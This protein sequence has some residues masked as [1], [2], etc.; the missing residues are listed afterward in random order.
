MLCSNQ[1]RK[2]PVEQ[3]L[4]FLLFTNEIRCSLC[5][6]ILQ[7]IGVAFQFFYHIIHKI[8]KKNKY[9]I[10]AYCTSRYIRFQLRRDKITTLIS[11]NLLCIWTYNDIIVWI[12]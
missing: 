1:L 3:G 9:N 2:H 11:G 12:I 10:L 6:D 5:N 4:C 7:V 8:A